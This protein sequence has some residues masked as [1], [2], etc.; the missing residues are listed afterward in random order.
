MNA[1]KSAKTIGLPS[2]LAAIISRSQWS[3]GGL[4]FGESRPARRLSIRSPRERSDTG[5]FGLLLRQ[6]GGNLPIV[7]GQRTGN[8]KRGFIRFPLCLKTWT[9]LGYGCVALLRDRGKNR[10]HGPCCRGTGADATRDQPAAS[11]VGGRSRLPSP[12]AHGARSGYD[13]RGRSI[14][15]SCGAYSRFE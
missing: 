12:S 13:G 10:Q 11:E 8:L 1:A 5:A 2:V 9:R 4:S 3:V 6:T 15:A 7:I 14:S